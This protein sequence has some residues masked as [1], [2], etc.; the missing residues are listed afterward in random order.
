MF[1]LHGLDYEQCSILNNFRQAKGRADI[2]STLL[3]FFFFLFGTW[4]FGHNYFTREIECWCN[5]FETPEENFI[6]QR[7]REQA[8]KPHSIT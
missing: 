8:H 3:S 2:R 6:K 1:D 5:S 4:R 7:K